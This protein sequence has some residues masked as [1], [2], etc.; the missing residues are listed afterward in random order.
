VGPG[1]Y[2]F[3]G[4][5]GTSKT[6]H[7]LFESPGIMADMNC[8]KDWLSFGRGFD[9]TDSFAAALCAALGAAPGFADDQDLMILVLEVTPKLQ[10]MID[11]GVRFAEDDDTWARAM[12]VN[13]RRV[14]LQEPA[15]P[16]DFWSALSDNDDIVIPEVRDK[17][18]VAPIIDHPKQFNP[19]R[20]VRIGGELVF[21]T[22]FRDHRADVPLRQALHRVILID[23]DGFRATAGVA[24]ATGAGGE[25]GAAGGGGSGVGDILRSFADVKD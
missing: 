18:V 1:K 14:G 25:G 3:H 23:G 15:G 16:A 9:T 10:A 22:V 13:N 5:R 21:E 4:T 8:L 24:V 12:A 11:G 20:A 17:V 2:L 19:P 6:F 7:S